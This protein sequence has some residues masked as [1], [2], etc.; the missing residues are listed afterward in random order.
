M[1]GLARRRPLLVLTVIGTALVVAAPPVAAAPDVPPG[2]TSPVTGWVAFTID[3]PNPAPIGRTGLYQPVSLVRHSDLSGSALK[4][5]FSN[6]ENFDFDS[7]PLTPETPGWPADFSTVGIEL[8][9]VKP[10]PA[11]ADHCDYT[12]V[13]GGGHA[14]FVFAGV[15][16][17]DAATALPTFDPEALYGQ[18]TL[19]LAPAPQVHAGFDLDLNPVPAAGGTA[20]KITLNAV[21][22]THDDLTGTTLRY[23]WFVQNLTTTKVFTATGETTDLTLDQDGDYCIVLEVTASDGATAQTPE[24]GSSGAG[25]FTATGFAPA[26]P[27]PTPAPGTGGGAPSGGGLAFAKPITGRAAGDGGALVSA[28]T[29][30]W[31]WR[32]EQFQATPEE[33]AA[34]KTTNRPNLQGRR[35]VVVDA[36]SPGGASAGPWLAGVGLFG[37]IGGGWI[38]RRRRMLRLPVED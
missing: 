23:E 24:C 21:G 34:P 28:P 20:G 9:R 17:T 5:A 33:T 16:P 37:L 6:W 35:E 4:H 10:C 11:A 32:P 13:N 12:V 29:V 7:N 22:I 3:P 19:D 26:A 8:H 36:S 18:D 25:V 38:I 14:I 31:L 2:W 27:A 15:V 1:R 30:T